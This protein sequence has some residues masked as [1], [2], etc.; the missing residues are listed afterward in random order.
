MKDPY[1]NSGPDMTQEGG[2][3]KPRKDIYVPSGLYDGRL[4][5]YVEL[6]VQKRPAFRGEARSPMPHAGLVFCLPSEKAVYDEEVGEVQMLIT[7]NMPIMTGDKSKMKRFFNAITDPR[8]PHTQG[9]KTFASMAFRMV[10][11]VIKIDTN[12]KTLADGTVKHYCNVRPDGIEP[13]VERVRNKDTKKYEE[14]PRTDIDEFE[15]SPIIFLWNQPTIEDWDRL[16]KWMRD[17]IM[18]AENF[19]GSPIYN[20]LAENGRLEEHDKGANDGMGDADTDPT[21]PDEVPF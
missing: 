3:F 14:V 6:G 17:R 2:G 19:A 13:P 1:A 12:E 9:L 11:I 7:E 21:N 5:G 8:N 10:P 20:L 4:V 15:E 18:G 16:L